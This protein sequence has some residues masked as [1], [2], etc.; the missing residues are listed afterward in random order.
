MK[1]F[2]VTF[3]TA[4]LISCQAGKEVAEENL[5][6]F[7]PFPL[8][9][10]EQNSLMSEWA[11]KP[12]LDTRL[13]DNMEKESGW[14]VTGIGEMSFTSERSK[15]GKKSL[16][17][18]TSLRDEEHYR[19]NRTEWGSFGGTQGGNASVQLKFNE[20][21]NWSDYNRLSFWVYVHPSDI[22]TY[23]LNLNLDNE[24]TVYTAT[25]PRNG[26]FIQ[27]LKP[28]EWNN[29]LFEIPHIKRDRIT[30]I[31]INQMLTGHN[32]E[33]KGVVTYDIDKIELQKVETDPFEGWNVIPGKISFSHAGYRP[34]DPKVAMAG[35]GA[36]KTFKVID[37]SGN[38]VFSGNVNIINNKNGVFQQLNFSELT[39]S[40]IYTIQTGEIRSGM[41]RIDENIW[42]Q[43]V[44]KAIN[45]FWCERCGYNVPGIHLE[46]HKDL[47]GFKGEEKKIIN[48]GWHDA[49]DLSQGSWRTAMSTL[50]MM[51]NL[52][53]I[54]EK[55][56]ATELAT[57]IREEIV[58]GLE[59]L[60]KTRFGDGYHM[61][62][63]VTRMYTDNKVG[64]IDDIVT[65]ARNVPWENFLAAAVQCKAA[66]MLEKS[67]PELAT[68]S[69]TA[70]IEDWQAAVDSQKK[71]E[72]ADYKE[73]SWGVTSS[74]LL[75]RMTGE[76]K[77]RE[78]AVS[79]GKLLIS[80]Q[81]QSFLDG[82]PVTG[83]FYENTGREK[84]I[85]NL[86]A[87]FE[88]AP[89]IALAMLCKEL[90]DNQNWMEWYGAAVLHSEY[91]MKQ[92]SLIAAP[93]FN[94][95][96]SVWKKSDIM[97]EKD[98][99]VR[100]DMLRQFKDGTPLKGEYVL[101]TFPIYRDGLFHGNTNIHMSSTWALA[102]ASRLRQDSA[103]MQLVGKQLEWVLGANPF[104][105]SL[106][107][108]A[109][110]GFAPQFA[111]C[112]KDI[113]GSLPVGMDCMNGDMPHWC[114]TNTATSKE[115]W[116]EPVNRF[117]GAVS[118]YAN[119]DNMKPGGNE[120][121]KDAVFKI[122]K[123]IA[124]DGTV[125]L[126]V[127]ITGSGSHKIDLRTFNAKTNNESQKFEL[128]GNSTAET[129]FKLKVTDRNKPYV[130][131]VTLDNDQVSRMEVV[132]SLI[133][134]SLNQ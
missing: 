102:E 111:Y 80:C 110:Y 132:G 39:K 30:A 48:G 69:R 116:V 10:P 121:P 83:Y 68:K 44:F 119:Y 98:T 19:K 64:T 67:H 56:D 117:L 29:V 32:P 16:R 57:R 47:Q 79:F 27:D 127:V 13:V 70:A 77:Y 123:S 90:P 55:S 26:H 22:M 122:E 5:L 99:L 109:G 36:G 40:G 8:A 134:T 75:A 103:G 106:M 94:L 71:W 91:F 24:G 87:A 107:Y 18:R 120:Q 25:T 34:G 95:P 118:V 53:S 88:E 38:T 92:G 131:L 15:D 93:Y 130:A 60:L 1:K 124:D 20:P 62:F 11:K 115:I 81:E 49:G 42:L 28:G 73:A 72:K 125:S 129:I 113:V 89:L 9:V 66:M 51:N 33:E 52:E 108:G 31:K 3:L 35:K 100:A 82:I 85:H 50:A 41:F 114:A 6:T 104:G 46:C 58:W 112:L 84:V 21:Q 65:P 97:A 128:S 37:K 4:T 76:E 101:R 63:S 74:L 7:S 133:E 96:N 86:H 45:F 2:L 78:Y 54:Q 105:Q 43:P 61:S 126:K 23:C 59:W 17:F 12:V 14:I